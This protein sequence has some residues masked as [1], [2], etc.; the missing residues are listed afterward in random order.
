M[1]RAE[2]K[3]EIMALVEPDAE[4]YYHTIGMLMD[5]MSDEQLDKVLKHLK[6]KK[7][8]DPDEC[9]CEFVGD[10]LWSCGHEDHATPEIVDE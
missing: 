2:K 7:D 9:G 10:G 5:E 3:K 6:G 1:T 8:H 4:V